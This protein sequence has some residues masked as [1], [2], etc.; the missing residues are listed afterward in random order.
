MC[1]TANRYFTLPS[2]FLKIY[3][4]NSK[5]FHFQL[6][7]KQLGTLHPTT[8]F[9]T[10]QQKC[11]HNYG[12]SNGHFYSMFDFRGSVSQY[13]HKLKLQVSMPARWIRPR[14]K[15]AISSTGSGHD[16]NITL[17]RENL[18]TNL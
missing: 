15:K 13:L 3:S 6:L 17:R 8:P 4:Q 12:V 1:G 5:L 18:E 14:H 9:C 2:T 7:S 11:G 10:K 16:G